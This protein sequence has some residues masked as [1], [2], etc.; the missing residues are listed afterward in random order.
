MFGGNGGKEYIAFD[1]RGSQPW[2]VVAID[3]TNIDISENVMFVARDFQAFL[4]FVGTV[5]EEA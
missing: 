2:P 1:L 4:S 3:M 5:A